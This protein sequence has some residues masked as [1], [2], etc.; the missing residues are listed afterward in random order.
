MEP[1][2]LKDFLEK[3]QQKLQFSLGTILIVT[4]IVAVV[5]GV[6]VYALRK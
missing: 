4:T 6:A 5:L 3:P 1:D 2:D